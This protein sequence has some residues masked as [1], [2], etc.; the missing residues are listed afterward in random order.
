[1]LGS[2]QWIER[3]GPGQ[4]GPE[5]REKGTCQSGHRISGNDVL[6]LCA[7]ESN[8]KNTTNTCIRNTHGDKIQRTKLYIRSI[9]AAYVLP[10]SVS[11]VSRALTSMLA[12]ILY[13]TV[14]IFIIN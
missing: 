10:K 5:Y 6:L 9:I 2:C 11:S 3:R 13:F 12:N 7:L 8:S 4:S 14:I 1:M